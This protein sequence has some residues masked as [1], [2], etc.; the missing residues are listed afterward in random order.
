MTDEKAQELAQRIAAILQESENDSGDFAS[1]R[2][3]L[4][5]FNERLD[6]IEAQISTNSKSPIPNSK[7]LH[8]S[9]E[10]FASLEELAD[11]IIEHLGNEKACSFEP[12]GKPCDHCAM[13]SSRGF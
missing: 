6:K 13:C 11:E 7:P 4:E 10:K 12:N 5:K 8:A 1:L 3:T 2:S 9:L